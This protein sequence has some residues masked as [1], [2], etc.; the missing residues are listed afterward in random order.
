MADYVLESFHDLLTKESE[1]ISDSDSS[2]GSHP[3]LECLMA[4]S[5][6]GRVESTHD[7]NTAPDMFDD[8]ARERNQAPSLVLLEQL[9]ERQKELEETRLQ[10][11]QEYAKLELKIGHHR[12][13][14]RHVPTP[15]VSIGGSS[16]MARDSHSLPR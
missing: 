1:T 15:V 3:S 13:G 7:G 10:L 16:R 9:R 14:G 8:G 12:G 6:E 11:E 2:R 5:P 4:D